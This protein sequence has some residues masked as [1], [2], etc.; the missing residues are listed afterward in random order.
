LRKDEESVLALLA[1]GYKDLEE[2][3]RD[4]STS[5]INAAYWGM[6]SSVKALLLAGANKD[7]KDD[8]STSDACDDPLMIPADDPSMASGWRHGPHQGCL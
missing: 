7:A 5:L 2:K 6:D 3:D 8:V 1:A 4:G